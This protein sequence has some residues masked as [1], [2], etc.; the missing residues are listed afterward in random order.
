[1]DAGKG[2]N[3][4]SELL[5]L[6]GLLYFA[7]MKK[8]KDLQVLGDSKV[9][10]DWAL[11]K[12]NIHILELD[13]WLVRV[14]SLVSQFRELKFLHIYRAYNMEAVDLSKKAISAG[15]GLIFWEEFKEDC[16]KDSRSMKL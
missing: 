3:T 6:W 10:I 1:M 8:I 12:H 15:N 4:K 2:T 11:D 5:A 13:P 16:L 7:S 14:K 9:I